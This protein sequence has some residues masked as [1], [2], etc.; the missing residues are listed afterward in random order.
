[1]P[2]PSHRREAQSRSEASRHRTLSTL[3]PQGLGLGLLAVLQEMIKIPRGTKSCLLQSPT[4]ALLRRRPSA[5]RGHGAQTLAR[6][7]RLRDFRL[8]LD[9]LDFRDFVYDGGYYFWW[10]LW[11]RRLRR[12]GSGAG[13]APVTTTSTLV[14][15]C[16]LWTFGATRPLRGSCT[17][18]FST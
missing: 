15:R 3:R 12:C 8:R 17:P 16:F 14:S 10:L 5:L 6:W 13:P 1:M 9:Y 11:G 18:S 2:Q 4:W 7:C